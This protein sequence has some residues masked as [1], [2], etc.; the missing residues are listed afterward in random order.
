MFSKIGSCMYCMRKSF[1]ALFVSLI[2]LSFTFAINDV[3]HLKYIVV[4][5]ITLSSSLACLWILHLLTY[6]L[7]LTKNSV[8]TIDDDS[9]DS[10]K[11]KAMGIFFRALSAA[12]VTT[13]FPRLVSAGVYGCSFDDLQT[14]GLY[15][16]GPGGLCCKEF[17][18]LCCECNGYIFCQP[19]EIGPCRC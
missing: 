11:R 10:Q 5:S 1:I 12:A 7:R 18:E 8:E 19:R 15:R 2:F 13:V 9:I 17:V 3:Y 4:F 16:C 6:S 14:K